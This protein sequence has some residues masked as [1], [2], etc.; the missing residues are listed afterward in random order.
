MASSF[1]LV[2]FGDKDS[3]KAIIEI[4]MAYFGK[5]GTQTATVNPPEQPQWNSA[6]NN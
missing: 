4:M 3:E 2:P 6:I 1:L 5:K